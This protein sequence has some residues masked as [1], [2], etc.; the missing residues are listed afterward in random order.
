MAAQPV[1][2]ASPQRRVRMLSECKLFAV[3]HAL[4]VKAGDP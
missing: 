4:E 1:V 2:D 3:C